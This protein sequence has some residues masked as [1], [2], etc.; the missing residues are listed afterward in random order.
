MLIIS[1][2][3]QI[4]LYRQQTDPQP[5]TYH[6]VAYPRSNYTIGLSHGTYYV[7]LVAV[8]R[9]GFSVDESVRIEV[10]VGNGSPRIGGNPSDIQVLDYPWVYILIP[11]VICL[12]II[13]VI[14][15]VIFKKVHESKKRTVT[16]CRGER[17]FLGTLHSLENRK[18]P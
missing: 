10:V 9:R 15:L 6:R 12:V 16:Y 1:R 14:T 3:P 11:G 17:L 7:S 2:P 13:V 8:N 5:F 18:I 4:Y